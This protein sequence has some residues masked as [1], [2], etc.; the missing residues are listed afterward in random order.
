MLFCREVV[1]F[2]LLALTDHVVAG[3]VA[4]AAHPFR[5]VRSCACVT[6]LS[7]LFKTIT[8]IITGCAHFS[9]V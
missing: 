8:L 5:I 6:A 1:L 9:R 4:L 7:A 2:R 3:E